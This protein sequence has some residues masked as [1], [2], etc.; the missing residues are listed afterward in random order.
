MCEKSRENKLKLLQILG[1]LHRFLKIREFSADSAK[2]AEILVRLERIVG[3]H[4]KYFF[5]KIFPP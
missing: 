5:D 2:E 4:H 1:D 3:E